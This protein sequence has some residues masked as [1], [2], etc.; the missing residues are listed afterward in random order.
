MKMP[1]PWREQA[2]KLPMP[3]HEI[4]QHI[5]EGMIKARKGKGSHT[6][7]TLKQLLTA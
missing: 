1:T 4:H 3:L 7:E 2:D 5:I 6:G